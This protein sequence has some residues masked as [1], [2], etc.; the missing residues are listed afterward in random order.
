MTRQRTN[1]AW[2]DALSDEDLSFV[3]RFVQASG[4]LKALA[5]SYGVSYPTIRL[6]LDR[7]IDKINVSDSQEIASP[8]E[9]RLR[10]LYAEGRID[11]ETL[12]TLLAAHRE[13]M[14]K[15]QE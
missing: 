9:R 2:L 6:R 12:K 1:A 5:A 13:E 10:L 8:F 7:L 14:R 4:S 11:M 15:E 3:K